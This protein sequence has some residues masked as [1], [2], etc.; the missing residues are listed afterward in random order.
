MFKASELMYMK[1][2]EID[3][4]SEL[5]SERFDNALDLM[6]KNAMVYGGALR[7]SLAGLP[8][9]G[10]LDIS[11]PPEELEEIIGNFQ[12]SSKWM[13]VERDGENVSIPSPEPVGVR[14]LKK[15]RG[16]EPS[17]TQAIIGQPGN[18]RSPLFPNATM[19]KFQIQKVNPS[20]YQ[21]IH[22]ESPYK[23]GRSKMSLTGIFTFEMTGGIRVQIMIAKKPETL[24]NSLFSTPKQIALFPAR[25]VDIRCCGLA[26]DKYGHLFE[27]VKGAYSDCKEKM[28]R[29]NKL[30]HEDSFENLNFRVDKLI[31][32]GWASEI[33]LDEAKKEINRLKKE[34]S[35]KEKRRKE[36]EAKKLERHF[37]RKKNALTGWGPVENNNKKDR[38]IIATILNGSI[39]VEGKRS[40]RFYKGKP[41]YELVI[42]TQ[43]IKQHFN[44]DAYTQTYIVNL[45]KFIQ[46]YFSPEELSQSLTIIAE[47]D[48]KEEEILKLVGTEAAIAGV[49]A[50]LNDWEK[51]RKTKNGAINFN[52]KYSGTKAEGIVGSKNR[53]QWLKIATYQTAPTK[54][55]PK[56]KKKKTIKKIKP[57]KQNYDMEGVFFET[58][59]GDPAEKPTENYKPQEGY[60]EGYAKLDYNHHKNLEWGKWKGSEVGS[61]RKRQPPAEEITALTEKNVFTVED[62]ANKPISL[63][64][65]VDDGESKFLSLEIGNVIIEIQIEGRDLVTHVHAEN[66]SSHWHKR[67]N[68]WASSQKISSYL[69]ADFAVDATRRVRKLT[70]ESNS[71]V[72]EQIKPSGFAHIISEMIAESIEKVVKRKLVK[73]SSRNPEQKYLNAVWAENPHWGD[74][75]NY[76]VSYDGKKEVKADDD[77]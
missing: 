29:L 7:D 74:L 60:Y 59:V 38:K 31:N 11:A 39:I 54:A 37:N 75:E 24:L 58:S 15:V 4:I 13:I 45:R 48:G 46:T 51:F 68:P 52:E 67:L 43:K 72:E 1:E 69:L 57:H 25:T 56:S 12:S 71:G 55:K 64:E 10:D 16:R 61:I 20:K 44:S 26:M 2:I 63:I 8:L 47:S 42:P 62:I 23:K 40:N 70:Q 21:L 19:P 77:F 53:T 34:E 6:T 65:N 18:A 17:I 50:M 27:V 33:N 49:F 73:S 22:A 35:I 30:T 66:G 32:R 3:W 9:K 41:R 36:R 14:D 76:E 28:L 5:I